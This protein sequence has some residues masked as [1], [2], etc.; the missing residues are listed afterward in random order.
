MGY[1][2][3]NCGYKYARI[4]CKNYQQQVKTE[5]WEIV[6]SWCIGHIKLNAT[7]RCS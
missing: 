6:K 1:K 3:D 4:F 7:T 2:C 5:K